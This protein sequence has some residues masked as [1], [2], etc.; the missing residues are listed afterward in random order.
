M[1]KIFILAVATILFAFKTFDSNYFA[2]S[3]GS[4]SQNW[5]NTGLITTDD[6]WTGVPSI[7]GFRG[8]GLAASTA[9]DPRTIL[10]ADDPGVLDVNANNA[11]PNTFTTGGVAEFNIADPVVALQGSGT[12]RAPY[13]KIYLNTTGRGNINVQYNIR[14]VDGSADNSVQPVALQYRVGNSG[15]FT[16]IA[17]AF[18]ADATTGPSLATLVTAVNV[19]L[20]AACENQ[21]MIELRIM[22]S[23]AVGSD[24]WVGIDDINITSDPIG[25]G[26]VSVT[27]G[28]NPSEPGTTGS[29]TINFSVPTSVSTDVNFAYTGG[30]AFGTDYSV[31]YS[32]G[33]A[34]TI[35]SS[36]VLTV[37]AGTSSVTVTITPIDDLTVEGAEGITLTLTTP[38]AGYTIGTGA[39]SIDLLD[40]DIAPTVSVAAG[41]NAAEPS[42]NGS[43]TISFSSATAASTNVNYAYTGTAGFG[44]DYTVSYS[45]GSPSTATSTGVLTIPAGISSVTVTITPVN[46]PDV[47]V[48]ETIILTLSAPGGGYTLGTPS[49]T[50]NI[51]SDDIPPATPIVLTG[52]PYAQDF[53]TLANTGTANNIIIQGWLLNETGTSARVNGQYAA[54]N[55]GSNTADVYSYGAAASTDRAFGGLLSGT[56]NPTIGA[57]FIN[58]TGTT[59]SR[60]K[61]TYTGEEWRLGTINRTDQLNFQYSLNATSLAT[62]TW[63]DVDPLDFVTPFTTTAGAVVG[64]NVGNKTLRSFTITGLSIANGSIFYIRWTDLDASGADDGLSVD[65]FSIETNPIDVTGPVATA[66]SPV[67]GATNIQTTQTAI[68]TFDE[69]IQKGTGSISVKRV[70]DNVTVQ[71]IDI[72]TAAVTVAGN[73]ASFDI[74]GLLFSTS[75]Y[76]EITAGAFKDVLNN[77]FAGISG[78]STWTFTTVGPPPP[79][80]IGNTYN[81]NV[82]T[83]PFTNGFS[84]FSVVGPQLWDCTTFGIDAAHTPAGSAP[85]GVQINGFSGTNIPNEDWLISPVFDLTGT[86]YPLLSFW[87]RTAFNGL[88][89]Q[90]KVSTD[91]PGAGNP[92]NYTWTDLNG[93][94]PAQTSNVWTLSEN[95][96]LS[97]FK[98]THTYFAFVYLSSDDDGARWTLDDILVAN[99]LVPPPPSLTVSTTDIQFPFVP[100][101][102][103]TDKSFTFIGNDLVNNITLNATG[104][105]QIS[106]D[107]ISFS[108]SLLYTIA[109]A[110]NIGKTVYVRFAPGVNN[111]DFSGNIHFATGSLTADV[112]LKGTSIDPATTLEVVNWN[113]EWFGSPTMAPNNDNLQEQNVKTILQNIG[114]DIFGVVEV[115]DEARLANVVSQ[116]P[117]YSYVIGNFGSHVNPPDPTGGPL[118]AAQ[119]LAFIYKTSMFSNISTRPLINNLNTASVSYNNWASGRYP[120][121]MTADVTLNCVTKTLNFVLIHAKANTSPTATSYARRLASANEL[122]DTLETYFSDK[123]VIV[124]GD[125]ND[126]LD[127]SI[128][129]G[130]TTTS[131]IAFMNDPAHY[132]S[133]TLALSLAGKKSTVSY[134]DVIDHV[135]LSNELVPYYMP[136]SA[137][138]LTD[139]ANLVNNYGST[140]TD[141]YPVFTRY[142]FNNTIAPGIVSCTGSVNFCANAG[143]SYTIPLFSASDDCNEPVTYTFTITGA[144]TRSG[145][146][147]DASGNFNPGVSTITWTASDSWGNTAS[148]QTI[149]TVNNNPQVTIPDAYALPSGVLPNTVY[150]GYS[151]ASSITLTS[152][153]SSGTPSYSY[154][155]SSGSTTASTTVSPVTATTYTLTVTDANGCQGIASK[156][157]SVMDIRGGKNNDK[158]VI[159]HNPT[160]HMNTLVISPGDVANHLAHGDMLGSCTSPSRNEIITRNSPEEIPGYELKARALPNPSAQYFTIDLGG[161]KQGEELSVRV[162]DMSG[163]LVEQIINLQAH[164]TLKIGSQYKAGIYIAEIRQGKERVIL[165]LVKILD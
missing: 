41:V 130:F 104:S 10:V 43:F 1:K 44:T 67:N 102:S 7:Q 55:G 50:I 5:S 30:A 24:E 59:V 28:S 62:G 17:A 127:Q 13:I 46:D 141:H 143:N 118:S 145:S 91:Y 58:N 2:L 108:P 42:T 161:Y 63:T 90:L 51:N 106:K 116:M 151:P 33:S 153:T 56:L 110:N 154:V 76:I 159:C 100:A 83:T 49:A 22:T 109:E 32:T 96:N 78:N 112:S 121:L 64:N 113:L 150:I 148:C 111:Q 36:G 165:K 103:F 114:A 85:N 160:R 129:D 34:N 37:P 52:V 38:T 125:F 40:N 69:N 120:F 27:A 75:Y 12:A 136:G 97:A 53:N 9:V 3:G 146:S 68:I 119:K 6:I 164:Q 70:S 29:F 23:D 163:R 133:P 71:T 142:R 94:F 162:T 39:A 81:F 132:F 21:S 95:I 73:V 18:V 128:T 124:L 135:M 60:L 131:Y 15:T 54:D 157:I 105:F 77:N 92:N 89:L 47:E 147:N 8:D 35:T 65:D 16:N 86:T 99:S 122:H 93:R 25:A 139:V 74:T 138:I 144:T 57:F 48:S 117:G 19:N 20:P 26:T 72:S 115:V 80:I 14:D 82:C 156:L 155:W 45:S 137:N 66:F 98:S 79:G 158:V 152:S 149:V 101:G 4:F 134:N 61:I 11:N 88:P 140:T 126:D 87:S 107:G 123:N 31:A 84:Q